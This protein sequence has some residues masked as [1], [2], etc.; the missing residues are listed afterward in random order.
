MLTATAIVSLMLVG[1]TPSVSYARL[2][3]AEA[4]E[5]LRTAE[6]VDRER[7]SVGVTESHRV[8]LRDGERTLRA[9]WKTIDEYK[10]VKRFDDGGLPELGFR[11]S[12]KSEIAAYELAGLLGLDFVPPTVFRR[13]DR[14]PGSLQLWVEG[15]ITEG[16]RRREHKNPPNRKRWTRQVYNA[17]MFH[18]LIHDSDYENVSN[19]LIDEDFELWVIDQ[20]RAFR[21]QARLLNREYLRQMPSESLERLRELTPELLEQELGE[22]LSPAQRKG[23]LDR[24]DLLL[25]HAAELAAGRG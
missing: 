4:E 19:L 18:Q 22:W 16:E 10:P 13:L 5:F 1:G 3:G 9:V 15:C 24:R 25:E 11:D 7:L 23:L 12:Y 21:T 20:S 17:R 14:V 2:T 6:I 8:T